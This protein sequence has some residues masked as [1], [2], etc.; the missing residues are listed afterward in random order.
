MDATIARNWT[1]TTTAENAAAY[2]DHLRAEVLTGLRDLDGFRGAR[3]LRREI[4]DGF[5]FQVLT[6]WNS[7]HSI[8]AFA[9][10]RIQTAVVPEAARRVLSRFDLEVTHHEVLESL[11]R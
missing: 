9:G 11:D 10:E 1:G 8:E 3:V 7:L 6:F 5:E 2:L 4:E